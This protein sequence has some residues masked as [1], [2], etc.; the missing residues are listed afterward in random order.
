MN[1]VH[2]ALENKYGVDDFMMADQLE[3]IADQLVMTYRRGALP[4]MN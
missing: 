3:Y 2:D 4:P 1:A